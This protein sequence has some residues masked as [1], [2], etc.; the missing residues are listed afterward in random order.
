VVGACGVVVAPAGGVAEGVVGVVD[1][2]EFA[3]A[4]GALWG[5]GGYAIGVVLEGGSGSCQFSESEEGWLFT[6]F[7]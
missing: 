6:Y 7:L 3:S 2:L 5:V 1:L 4:C